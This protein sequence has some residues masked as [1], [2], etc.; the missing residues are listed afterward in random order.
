MSPTI[1]TSR[2]ISTIGATTSCPTK[3]SSFNHAS[4]GVGAA[5]TTG[6]VETAS[7]TSEFVTG[8]TAASTLGTVPKVS[9]RAAASNVHIAG[10]STGP[11]G[12]VPANGSTIALIKPA[13]A[14]ATTSTRS[15]GAGGLVVGATESSVTADVD[16]ADASGPAP[17]IGSASAIA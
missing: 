12:A 3:G 5:A 14:V 4:G 8:F 13:I 7:D 17:T 6:A 11:V 1:G 10:D 2:R 15:C 16:T 9:R